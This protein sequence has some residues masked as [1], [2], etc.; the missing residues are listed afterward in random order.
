MNSKFCLFSLFSPFF[1]PSMEFVVQYMAGDH[2][3]NKLSPS[4]ESFEWKN[5]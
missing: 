2:D 1:I 3:G 4:I 5:S